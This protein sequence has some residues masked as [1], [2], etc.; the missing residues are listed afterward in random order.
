MSGLWLEISSFVLEVSKV[1]QENYY[2]QFIS[3]NP[4]KL[5]LNGQ[6]GIGPFAASM[7][8]WGLRDL[9]N[10]LGAGRNKVHWL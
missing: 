7:I 9:V 5:K 3:N 4:S 6:P 2:H 10:E 1:V 8:K